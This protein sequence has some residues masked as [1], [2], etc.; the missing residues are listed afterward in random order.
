MSSSLKSRHSRIDSP[1]AKYSQTGQLSCIICNQIIK[2]ESLWTA[3]INS[4]SHLINKDKL[5]D[6]LLKEQQQQQQQQNK[7]VNSFKRPSNPSDD[8]Q[9]NEKSFKKLKIESETETV[10]S[11]KNKLK[12]ICDEEEKKLDTSPQSESISI[13]ISKGDST[14]IIQNSPQK[15]EK[16][17]EETTNLPSNP[18]IGSNLPEGFFDNQEIDDKVRGVSRAQNLEAEYEEFKRIMQTETIKSDNIVEID[19][20]TR[21]ADRDLEEVDELINRWS[22]I[23]SL[24]QKRE[25]LLKNRIIKKTTA[26]TTN[27][28]QRQQKGD[29]DSD[30]DIDLDTVLNLTMRNKERC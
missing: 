8:K 5:K 4:K 10:H 26:E 15:E 24:H 28:R 30:S 22:K 20:K 16:E 17:E 9:S 13:S 11:K 23:E 18:L 19:D 29:S 3:H 2:V 12:D 1:I 7:D 27:R 6:V 25:Q 21:D 14:S